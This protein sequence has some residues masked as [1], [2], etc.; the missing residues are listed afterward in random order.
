MSVED[1]ASLGLSVQTGTLGKDV[2]GTVGGQEATGEGQMLTVVGSGGAK[3]MQLRISGDEARTYGSV[4]FIEGIGESAVNL[5]T[6]IVGPDGTLDS[7]TA[8][9]TRDLERI[10]EERVRLDERITSYQERLV[11]QFTAADSLIA[12]LNNTGNYLTQQLAALAPQNFNQ[13]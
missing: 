7:K 6:N 9:L 4:N 3:G 8:S 11:S 13:N 12:Q 5:I 2:A 1:G 10:E